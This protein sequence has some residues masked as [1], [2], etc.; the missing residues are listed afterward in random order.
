M[1]LQ[2]HIK[3]INNY[4]NLNNN[5]DDDDYKNEYDPYILWLNDKNKILKNNNLLDIVNN[6]L[7]TLFKNIFNFK[8]LIGILFY[9]NF[10]KYKKSSI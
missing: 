1:P 2:M 3:K 10:I 5:E 8:F 9:I 4:N 6:I 7:N